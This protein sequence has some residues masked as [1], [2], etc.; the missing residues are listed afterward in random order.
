M[1]RFI[2]F[3]AFVIVLDIYA[4]QA[5]RF[6]VKGRWGTVLYFL[7]TVLVIG[8][9]FLQFATGDRRSWSAMTQFF[10]VTFIIMILS[11]MVLIAVMFGEDIFRSLEGLYYKLSGK[12]TSYTLPSR[13]KFVSQIALGLAAIPF[14]S[15]LYGVIKG[16]YNFKVLKYT[17]HYED[18]PDAFDGYRITQISDIHSGSFDNKEKVS[19]AIDLINEQA[20]DAI[21]FTG[22]MVNNEAKEMEPY[23]DI[24]SKLKAKDGKFSVLGNHDYGDY[25][26]WESDEQKA[27]NL[28]RLKEIQKE[29]GFDLIL[30]DSRFLERD[31]QRIALVGVENWG[32]GGFKKAGD[33][34]KAIE[35]IASDDFKVLL[36]HDPSHWDNEV[37][38]HKDH[39]HLTLSGHTHGMQF[40][41]EIPG[42]I[43]W[44]PVKWRYK[45][46]AGIYK[47]KG[48][49]INVN[50]GFGYLAFPGRVGIWPEI[51][52]IELKKGS[53]TA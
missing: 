35:N 28:D 22:D 30:N 31:G 10:I 23:M 27:A 14:A 45:H 53:K 2:L 34:N 24:F 9:L 1:I 19:Y 21:L 12:N 48:Q 13:R 7:I 39:F 44:S 40:G 41:I 49:Y 47:E 8:G 42:W 3:I 50:R 52:V 32:A 16:R 6:L 46:W 18:L 33:L 29:I 4:Y 37:V 26:S 20:S 25:V 15:I 17:L 43:K 11:K 38:S 51:T 5:F 36:S